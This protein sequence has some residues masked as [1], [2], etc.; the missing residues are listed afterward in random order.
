[1]LESFAPEAP[2]L[3]FGL[4]G[5]DG[6]RTCDEIIRRQARRIDCVMLKGNPTE[7]LVLDARESGIRHVVRKP[8]RFSELQRLMEALTAGIANN[9]TDLNE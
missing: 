4:P 7:Q 6:L 1:M 9:A 8:I 2:V 5:V 3:D